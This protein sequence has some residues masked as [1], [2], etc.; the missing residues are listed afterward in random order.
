MARGTAIRQRGPAVTIW[1]Y[2]ILFLPSLLV[3]LPAYL[4]RMR[5][6]GGH[7]ENLRHRFGGHPGLGPRTPGTRRVWLQAVSVGELLA[8]APILEALK[9]EGVET[10]LTTTTSTGY[11]IANDRFR[12]LT[13]GI[14]YFPIDWWPFSARAWRMI[15]PDLAVLTEGERWPEHVRQARRRGVPLVNINA[16]LSDRSFRRLR[17]CSRW[18]P[19]LARFV[20]DGIT[21]LLPASNLDERRFREL[22]FPPERMQ[23]TGNIKLDVVIPRLSVAELAALRGELGLPEGP[24]LLGSSTWPGEEEAEA[25]SG[26]WPPNVGPEG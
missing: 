15:D 2:R 14:G 17:F 13:C 6:R 25:V 23:V 21:R 11:R 19:P 7:G 18:A 24:V 3:L 4:R 20:L 5:R 16:R 1:I 12:G 9:R 8:V 26:H 22:G 10:Y